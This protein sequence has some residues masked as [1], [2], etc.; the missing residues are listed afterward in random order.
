M[1]VGE[2]QSTWVEVR[3]WDQKDDML[4]CQDQ[5]DQEPRC[6]LYFPGAS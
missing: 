6:E 1:E 2:Q 3:I 4:M 5:V